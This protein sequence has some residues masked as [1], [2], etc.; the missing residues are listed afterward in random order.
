M[1]DKAV[2]NGAKVIAPPRTIKDEHGLVRLATI[3][4]YGDTTH[5][6]VDRSG[7]QGSFLPGYRSEVFEDPIAKFV[8]PVTLEAIDHCVGNQDW[9]EMEDACD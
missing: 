1:F 3:K 5:T 7:Y 8:P 2:A 9:G 6:L 4:T